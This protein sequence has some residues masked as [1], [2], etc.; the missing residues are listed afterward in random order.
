[1]KAARH[2]RQRQHDG[3][4]HKGTPTPERIPLLS[5]LSPS[6]ASHLHFREILFFRN[7]WRTLGTKLHRRLPV[8]LPPAT[9]GPPSGARSSLPAPA[10]AA[11]ALALALRTECVPGRVSGFGPL[12][13]P[14]QPLCSLLCSLLAHA[15]PASFCAPL[16]APLKRQR[17][18]LKRQA[19][20]A[21]TLNSCWATSVRLLLSAKSDG[22]N[23]HLPQ[24]ASPRHRH[25]HRHTATPPQGRPCAC[26]FWGASA[27]RWPRATGSVGP[28]HRVSRR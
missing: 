2:K 13:A 5:T 16:C 9:A 7:L 11:P 19:A 27:G 26:Q 28:G 23:R 1:M 25:P 21:A 14:A 17:R 3:R 4:A 22:E 20:P 6:T 12:S 8:V 18:A 15:F 24:T 10:G